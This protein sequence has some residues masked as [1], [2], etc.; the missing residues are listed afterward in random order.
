MFTLWHL[1]TRKCAYTIP[2][3]DRAT[4]FEICIVRGHT[5]VRAAL[6]VKVLCIAMAGPNNSY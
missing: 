4:H 3:R 2:S 6:T 1:V 5:A